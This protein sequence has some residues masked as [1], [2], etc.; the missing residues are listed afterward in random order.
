MGVY[1]GTHVFYFMY[2]DVLTLGA[3]LTLERSAT[4]LSK[5][6]ARKHTF[7]IQTNQSRALIPPP[8]AVTLLP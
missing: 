4:S 3:L 8:P 7:Q 2:L 5:Q 1:G 6:L